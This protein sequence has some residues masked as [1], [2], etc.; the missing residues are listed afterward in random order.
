MNR[1][2][3][4]ADVPA[5]CNYLTKTAF[6]CP[7]ADLKSKLGLGGYVT[8]DHRS[9]GYA[10][11]I[12][13]PGVNPNSGAML[14]LHAVPNVDQDEV[15]RSYQYKK[16][17]LIRNPAQT[18]VLTDAQGFYVEYYDRGASL[19]QIS[20]LGVSAWAGR[21]LDAV[22]RHG[23]D[24]D[25]WNMAFFDGSA[26]LL[27]FKDVPGAPANRYNLGSGGRLNPDDL[28]TATDVSAD[29]KIFWIGQTP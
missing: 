14:A 16:I 13:T 3:D 19:N 4:P 11:N 9:N 10:L 29:T 18:M 5:P 23:K 15:V 1:P 28:L 12:S 8:T 25:A 24:Q 20:A 26:R 7:A 21:M 22:G 27:H 17:N 2:Y 6:E